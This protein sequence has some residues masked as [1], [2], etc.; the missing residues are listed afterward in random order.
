MLYN[1]FYIKKVKDCNK[2]TILLRRSMFFLHHTYICN[3]YGELCLYKYAYWLLFIIAIVSLKSKVSLTTNIL[4]YIKGSSIII[5][6]TNLI[7]TYLAEKY[8]HV[9]ILIHFK[10][11]NLDICD[12][13]KLRKTS[14]K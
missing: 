12:Q 6:F 11:W 1:V 10:K 3:Q 9:V 7:S 4:I 5:H 14:H 2:T 8:F 13:A